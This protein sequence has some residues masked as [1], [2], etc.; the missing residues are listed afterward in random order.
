MALGLHHLRYVVVIAEE[1]NVTRAARRLHLSQPSLSAAL[2]EVERQV[3]TDLFVR[4]PWGMAL[5]PA[6]EAFV[7]EARAAIGAADAAVTEARRAARGARQ[8]LR[9]GFIVG[10]QVELTSQIVAAFRDR[11]P[12]V[13]LDPVEHTFADPSAG[14]RSQ[15]VDVAFVMP[16]FVS[17][18]LVLE[19]LLTAP[20]VAV[21]ASSHPLAGRDFVE[22]GELFGEPWIYADTD[23]EV[24]RS[25]WL[26]MEHRTSP[27]ILGEGTRTIDRFIQLA[28]G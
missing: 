4:H 27:P 25:Y 20:R 26:A 13:A 18:G 10:T 5:T 22:I 9:V 21:L 2:R 11:H 7:A 14:L 15:Q 24:C 16:P 19:E 23:D 28:G 12:E 8:H 1:G 17:T 3:G 6:G